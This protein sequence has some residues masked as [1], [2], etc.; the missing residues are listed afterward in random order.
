MQETIPDNLKLIDRK[1]KEELYFENI[2]QMS[3]KIS[4]NIFFLHTFEIKTFYTTDNIL[5]RN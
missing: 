5:K 4:N 1:I 2:F 3:K